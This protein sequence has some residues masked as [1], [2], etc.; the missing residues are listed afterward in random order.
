MIDTSISEANGGI[1]SALP[2]EHDVEQ[3]QAPGTGACAGATRWL[4]K[5][6]Q[7][8]WLRVR[9]FMWG[10]PS[11][12]DRQLGRDSALSTGEYSVLST[13]SEAPDHQLRAG[14]A[15][16]DLGWERSRLS[17]LLR[18]MEAKGLI[19]RVP[20]RCDR[21]GHDVHLTALGW[22]TIQEAAPAHVSFIRETLF[23][24]LTPE[25]Q[26]VLASALRRVA[27]AAGRTR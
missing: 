14:D 6:E 26:Q 22:S 24:P 9:E 11:A 4:S 20:S 13:L 3:A 17:H 27:E 5:D 23:D 16:A 19:E 25:E 10:Y 7:E 2:A 1:V 12:L 8:T 15:A 18:R 21:R